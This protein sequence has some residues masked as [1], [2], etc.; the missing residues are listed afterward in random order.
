MMKTVKNYEIK[1]FKWYLSMFKNIISLNL[2]VTGR[3]NKM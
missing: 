2:S 1:S 3:K